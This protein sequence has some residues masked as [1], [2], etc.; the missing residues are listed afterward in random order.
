MLPLSQLQKMSLS[1]ISKAE[2]DVEED[3]PNPKSEP[4]APETVH[5]FKIQL[6]RDIALL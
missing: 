2:E 6:L 1:P 5:C 4:A 3:S